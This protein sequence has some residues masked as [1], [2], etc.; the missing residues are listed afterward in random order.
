MAILV[1]LVPLLEALERGRLSAL[2]GAALALGTAG[3]T[4]QNYGAL[5]LVAFGAVPLVEL[6]VDRRKSLLGQRPGA[7]LAV[8]LALPLGT[9][10]LYFAYHDALDDFLH[11]A[12]VVP[13]TATAAHFEIPYPPVLGVADYPIPYA[14]LASIH[15]WPYV[16]A[17]RSG[18]LSSR[19]RSVSTAGFLRSA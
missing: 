1:A 10:M 4:K 6:M 13:L 3:S 16:G 18:R 14:P 17:E 19:G 9:F 8:G 7:V 5:A 12:V 2:A 15:T 11:F